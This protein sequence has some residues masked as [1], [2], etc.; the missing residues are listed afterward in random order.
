MIVAL[1]D[2]QT[3]GYF[4]QNPIHRAELTVLQSV[5]PLPATKRDDI[6]PSSEGDRKSWNRSLV[7]VNAI[8]MPDGQS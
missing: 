6:N 7:L 5:F 1:N 2:N 3:K 4:Y 8:L